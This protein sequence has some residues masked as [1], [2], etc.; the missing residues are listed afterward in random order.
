MK[1]NCT[2]LDTTRWTVLAPSKPTKSIISTHSYFTIGRRPSDID[3]GPSTFSE[4]KVIL[5]RTPSPTTDSNGPIIELQLHKPSMINHR[6][7][8][9][10]SDRH[11]IVTPITTPNP[12][13]HPISM[14]T[15]CFGWRPQEC[16]EFFYCRRFLNKFV[17]KHIAYC[18]WT[19]WWK[20]FDMFYVNI[21][22]NFK[23]K[24]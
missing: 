8:D 23:F 24:F 3:I 12:I 18:W 11:K 2:P 14:V 21:F 19:N 9:L 16:G 5:Q 22:K 4:P 1:E 15:R 6:T 17:C 20:A 10:L 13:I 7:K